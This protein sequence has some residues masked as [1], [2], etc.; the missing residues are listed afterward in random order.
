MEK[1]VLARVNGAEITDMDIN[2]LIRSLDP[3]VAMQ[4]YSP[5]GQER[6]LEELINQELF[7][8]EAVENKFSEE[9]EFKAELEKMKKSALKQ[10]ALRKVL[11]EAVV[12]PEEV[13]N[14]YNSH[15][16]DYN[17]PEE[18]RASHI[19]V[20]TEE[21]AKDIINKINAGTSFEDAAKEHS[22]CPSSSA[23]GDLGA[24]TRGRMV[25]E[26]EEAAFKM[27]IGEISEPVQTQ[28][29]YHIIKVT[30][31]TP[32]GVMSFEEVKPQVESTV[33]SIKQQDKYLEKAKE[34][35]GKYTV[36]IIK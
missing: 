21:E 34:L 16:D 6:L 20:Q 18:V 17:K 12:T 1:K 22:S 4:F 9:E 23:G 15:K 26:F 32:A 29:G 10:Y 31:K 27:E 7:Y 24:F 35:K 8:T 19:L 2:L 25:P 13:E 33:L 36:E 11:A 30:E 14:F 28:F 3:Q 5:E